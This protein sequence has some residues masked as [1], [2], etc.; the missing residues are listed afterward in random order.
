MA[1]GSSNTKLNGGD[2]VSATQGSKG[3]AQVVGADS[4]S[5]KAL[6]FSCSNNEESTDNPARA[7]T[8]AV[9]HE[10][11]AAGAVSHA[12]APLKKQT[13]TVEQRRS[14]EEKAWLHLEDITAQFLLEHFTADS[15]DPTRCA[16]LGF[17]ARERQRGFDNKR[18]DCVLSATEGCGNFDEFQTQIGVG[19]SCKK[20]LK[21]ESPNQDDFSFIRCSAFGV[22]GVF[23]GHGPSGHQASDFVHRVLLLMLLSHPLLRTDLSTH[24]ALLEFCSEEKNVDSSLSGTTATLVL[25]EA[26][27]L[28]AAFVG[29]SRCV[30]AKMNRDGTI[31]PAFATVDHKPTN[32]LEKKRIEAA[33]Q[34]AV[35]DA[36]EGRFLTSLPCAHGRLMQVMPRASVYLELPA[37]YG[38]R[39]V[40]GS[41]SLGGEVM[42]LD[43]DIPHRV[44]V[45]DHLFPGL[46]MSRAIGDGIAHQIGVISEPEIV[47]VPLDE[48]SLFFI[49]ASDGVWEFISSEEAVSIVARYVTGSPDDSERMKDAADRLAY[50]AFRRWIDE[51]GNVVD[52]VRGFTQRHKG[53]YCSVAFVTG[54]W[55]MTSAKGQQAEE[56]LPTACLCFPRVA[57]RGAAASRS[58][59]AAAPLLDTAVPLEQRQIRIGE[60]KGEGSCQGG[61]SAVEERR[62]ETPWLLFSKGFSNVKAGFFGVVE[63]TAPTGEDLTA[64]FPLLLA[65]PLKRISRLNT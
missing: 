38:Q 57:G 12:K 55:F 26:G 32:P 40:W 51:E 10:V 43:C 64:Q 5:R 1:V 18:M 8:A 24:K 48:N 42:R 56:A 49:V 39:V 47:Q 23:D 61:F 63:V 28:T 52:D 62:H 46:A 34:F 22:Y 53:P 35:Q 19:C 20:G 59:A 54:L 17:P 13:S 21:P 2:G 16:V 25:H 6:S 45:K 9:P 27:R 41:K 4:S 44:F 60:R 15:P 29:D 7:V 33:G 65:S 3:Y 30:L 31:I 58:T 37:R 11:S 36:G 14:H 50:E